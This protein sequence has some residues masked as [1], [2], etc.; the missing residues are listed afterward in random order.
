MGIIR[1]NGNTITVPDGAN[2]SI[3]NGT[4][5]INGSISGS[6]SDNTPKIEITGNVGS[7]TCPGSVEVHGN[8]GGKVDAGGNVNCG[9]VASYVDAGGNVICGKVGGKV[10][11]GG[12]VMVR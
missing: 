3:N 1:I 4:I 8:V 10:D 7:L 12:N 2:V 9:D 5:I 6:Y 11:A